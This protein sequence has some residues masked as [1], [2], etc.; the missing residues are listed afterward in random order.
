MM[1]NLLNVLTFRSQLL[2]KSGLVWILLFTISESKACDICGCGA[3]N[4]YFGI[5]PQWDKNL[6]G[7]RYRSLPFQSHIYPND[8]YADLF[9]TKEKFE[10]ADFV[11]K[12]RLGQK[13]QVTSFISYAYS[14]QTRIEKT[15]RTNGLADLLILGQ[16]QLLN[17]DIAHPEKDWKHQIFMGAGLKIPTGKWDYQTEDEGYVENPN[18]QPGTGSWDY[19]ASA[20]YVLKY[21]S[22][23][24]QTDWQY[25]INGENSKRYHFGNRIMGNANLFYQWNLTGK[26]SLMPFAGLYVEHSEKNT[27][28]GFD[29]LETGGDLMMVNLG[30]QLFY[31]NLNLSIQSQVPGKQNLASDHIH[32][33]TRWIFQTN[34]SF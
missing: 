2:I 33:E 16:Y 5:M 10:I 30:L 22:W 4:L 13:W 34:V 1:K 17:T 7:I 18:F 3:G 9:L 27:K 12:V 31:K 32:A 21:K 20:Q 28:K 23:G 25:R 6:V 29:I 24:I 11:A 8:P 19:L 26:K 14:T 15:F